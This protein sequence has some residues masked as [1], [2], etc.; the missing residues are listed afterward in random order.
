MATTADAKQGKQK[1]I[2]IPAQPPHPIRRGTFEFLFAAPFPSLNTSLAGFALFASVGALFL[3]LSYR[4]LWHTD[5]WGHLAYGRWIVE[6]RAVPSTEPLMPL[7]RTVPFV[8]FSWLS[9]VI[10]YAT[11]RWNG[12]EAL[13]LLYAGC[14]TTCAGLLAWGVW[15]KTRSNLAAA[16]G[17]ALYLW[18][19][20]KQLAIVR[21]QLAGCICF[22]LLLVLART[23]RRVALPIPR[24][25][26]G[27][28]GGYEITACLVESKFPFP[29]TSLA[30]VI[31]FAAWA[32]LH[33]SF[34]VGLALLAATVCGRVS[35]VLRRTGRLR[36]VCDDRAARRGVVLLVIAMAA[37][38][39]N[40]YGWR[41]YSAAW[42]L[43]G[44]SNLA[45]L[46]EWR[47]LGLWMSQAHA[48]LAVSIGL[49]AVYSL[50]PRRISIAEPLLLVGFGAAAVT[51]SRMIVWWG[52]IAAYYAAL[53]AAAIA[54]RRPGTIFARAPRLKRVYAVCTTRMVPTSLP[55]VVIM[56][57]VFL[58]PVFTHDCLGRALGFYRDRSFSAQT[59][60]AAAEY[61]VENPPRG[62]IFN[63]LEWGD[64]LLWAGP[65]RLDVFVASHVHLIPRSV[66]QDYMRIIT[67]DDGWQKVL[68]RYR[69]NTA[70]VDDDQHAALADA[71]RED[72][73][74]SV[75]YE[76]AQ[77]LI[78]VRRQPL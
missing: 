50:T 65:A 8:D 42:Q 63:T 6:H 1:S 72:P 12:P 57:A 37:V 78:F 75:A 48:A 26:V 41:I 3:L 54:K 21:P 18:V 68:E 14:V 46:V 70:I 40:P 74:W 2:A 58:T 5:L 38:L 27:K 47:P 36:V 9:E 16:L 20:W 49:L 30:V 25:H 32:N 23:I 60:V 61:L 52:P 71:L 51:A 10:G 28:N 62:Q 53:H 76:D 4:P 45:D 77:G 59:P 7:C 13:Q 31:L 44:N 73:A 64:Y 39:L 29:L 22:M 55:V 34:L 11:Y 69:I 17:A 43:A 15:W 67:L 56:C 19:D 35:D 24:L 33:G 66:W